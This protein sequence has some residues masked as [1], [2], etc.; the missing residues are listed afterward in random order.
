[1]AE[2]SNMS[3]P[4]EVAA[5]LRKD[6]GAFILKVFL[7]VSPGDEYL[8][9]WHID[10]IVHEL[11]QIVDGENRRLIITQPPR[12]L[13]SIC[14]S[15]A[16]VA[17]WLGH[18]P[19]KRFI[20]V[21]YSNELAEKLAGQFRLVVQSDWYR[22]L[23]PNVR[24]VKDTAADLTTSRNGG[25]IAVSVGG[26]LT[27]LGADVIIIDDPLKAEDAQSDKARGRVN[28]W[29]QSTL[30]SRLDDKRE[31][32]IIL[33]MQRLHED[34]LAGRLL[35]QTEHRDE[36]SWRHLDLPAIAE[37]DQKVQ[38]G[39][40][41]FH[42]RRKGEALH[43]EREPL[44]EL[45]RQKAEMGSLRFS[46]QYQQRPVPAQGNL[47]SRQWLNRYDI[48]PLDAQGG[49]IV[50]SW[51]VAGTT[52]ETSN[53]SVCTTWLKVKKDYYLLDVWRDRV[54]FPDLKK[55]LHELARRFGANRILIEDAGLGLNLIQELRA[56]PQMGVPRPVAIKPKGDKVTRME[57][58]CARFEAGQVHLPKD[59][60]WLDGF[61]REILAFPYS[62]NDDQVDSV[63]QFLNWAEKPKYER[64]V[65]TGGVC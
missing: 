25:R 29:Y 43:E 34:D 63:S 57:A 45:H 61:E 40:K 32:A 60:P 58:Q 49:E 18:D 12:S 54:T 4:R 46:A 38:I 59:A 24:F 42:K 14:T 27:G 48:A 50:Q 53:F 1:M 35:S 11:M 17:W 39:P 37:E 64:T 20:C 22:A 3:L 47:I 51:D 30:L 56:N 13:K 44:E 9:N 52:G 2:L 62:R 31:G 10:A 28:D 41:A 19:S 6:L 23:F 7:T 15:V 26:T 55:K 65:A 36:K 8:H 5:G 21:S 16:L 33:V